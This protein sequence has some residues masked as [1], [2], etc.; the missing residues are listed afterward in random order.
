MEER[1]EQ[2]YVPEKKLSEQRREPTTNSNPVYQNG[3][4]D[5]IWTCMGHIGRR[6]FALSPLRH[7]LL[8]MLPPSCN[9]NS[10]SQVNKKN[11][12]TSSE[13]QDLSKLLIALTR[14]LFPWVSSHNIS[15]KESKNIYYTS[16]VW[17]IYKKI[18]LSTKTVNEVIFSFWQISDKSIIFILVWFER[19]LNL[20]QV[21]WQANFKV[22][23]DN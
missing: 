4:D 11:I 3:V 8:P 13:F 7:P 20:A 6:Q 18:I 15:C 2:E 5:G 21:R 14:N 1:G 10:N 16:T 23:L 17:I 22:A 12:F 19:S 9:E